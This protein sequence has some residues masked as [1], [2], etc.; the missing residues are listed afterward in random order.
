MSEG[1]FI[2]EIAEKLDMN[3]KTIRFYE[4]IGVIPKAERNASNYRI[5]SQEDLKRLSFIKKART[6]GLSI[7]DIKNIIDIKEKGNLPGHQV[8][9]LLEKESADIENKIR[10]MTQFKNK[11]D[12]CIINFKQNI[13][14]CCSGDY[15]GLIE[16]LFE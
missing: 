2:K 11:L 12:Q 7:D 3:P 6:L 4:E 16:S 8:I 10:E 15:C 1:L 13:D 5:Y 9:N 14:I